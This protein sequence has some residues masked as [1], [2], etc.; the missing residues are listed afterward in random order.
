MQGFRSDSVLISCRSRS[1]PYLV[2]VAIR[3]L[4][5]EFFCFESTSSLVYEDS[6]LVETSNNTSKPHYNS[7]E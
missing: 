1:V 2:G 7:F 3:C 5:T 4:A 6:N